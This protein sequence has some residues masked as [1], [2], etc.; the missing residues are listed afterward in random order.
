MAHDT[1]AAAEKMLCYVYAYV[2][3]FIV[4]YFR[5]IKQTF[6]HLQLLKCICQC[7]HVVISFR[8]IKQIKQ[9]FNHLQL[10]KCI[11][12]CFHSVNDVCNVVSIISATI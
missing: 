11:C 12:Q 10:L 1:V 4:I 5:M 2:N 6:N 7:F 9:M 8:M 3:V